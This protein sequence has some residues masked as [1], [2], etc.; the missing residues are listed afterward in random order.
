MDIVTLLGLSAGTLTTVS[1]LP[2]VIKTWRT[3]S[4]KDVSVV[5]F[6]LLTTGIVLWIAYGFLIGS[7]PIVAANGVS[8][9]FT[10]TML[11]LKIKYR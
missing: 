4:A 8:L 2:Q 11:V 7:L 6:V 1:F 9:F 3:R 5:M 10:F